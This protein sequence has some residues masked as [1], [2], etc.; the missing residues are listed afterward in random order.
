MIWELP[1]RDYEAVATGR[2]GALV[3]PSRIICC[4]ECI[5]K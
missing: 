3:L 1:S 5:V 4:I 2:R